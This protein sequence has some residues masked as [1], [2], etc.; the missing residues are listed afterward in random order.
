MASPL[1]RARPRRRRRRL[2]RRREEL[3]AIAHQLRRQRGIDRL[4]L[5]FL[6][7]L[8]SRPMLPS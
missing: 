5:D 1:R 7:E 3:K 2:Q 6:I 4:A 8:C